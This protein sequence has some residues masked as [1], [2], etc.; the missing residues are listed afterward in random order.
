VKILVVTD[1]PTHPPLA[2][3]R[4]CIVTYCRLLEELGHE[5]HVLY[6]HRDW[7]QT[8]AELESTHAAWG[9][10]F[11]LHRQSITD[12]LSQIWAHRVGFALHGGY[13]LDSLCP[14][15]LASTV[16]RIVERHG[17]DAVIVNYWSMTGAFQKLERRVRKVLYAHD[18]FADKLRRTGGKWLSTTPATEAAA[19]A[20]SHV[21]LAIQEDEATFFKT[22]TSRP[23]LTAFTHFPVVRQPF[24]GQKTVLYLGGPNRPNIEGLRW[25]L[26][27]AW[28]LVR[29]RDP[30][31]RLLVGGRI[32]REMS[33]YVGTENVTFQGDVDRL[34]DFYSQGDLTI[35]PTRT[36]TGL[37][38][39]TF[40]AMAHGKAL[41]C[42]PHCAEGIF[43]PQTAPLAIASTPEE[44]ATTICSQLAE[45][46]RLADDCEAS[47]R[48]IDSLDNFVAKQFELALLPLT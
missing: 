6:S 1:N 18:R 11:H 40:E 10:R 16:A 24:T 4:T 13:S 33:A 17:M 27:Q 25:F 7:V 42:H 9:E 8:S 43:E 5:V 41:I 12:R 35:N 48:Y 21:V 20:R 31:I 30:E 44:F 46:D 36:G 45:P 22:L 26:E 34:E 37:K 47:I 32:C 29:S 19:L 23:V 3:N 2:G 14:I 28:P 39:K 15:G 38:I